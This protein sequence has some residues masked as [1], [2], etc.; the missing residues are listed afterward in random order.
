[1]CGYGGMVDTYDLGSYAIDSVRVQ[2][3][4]SVLLQT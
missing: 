3:S 2:V 4:L 1:M